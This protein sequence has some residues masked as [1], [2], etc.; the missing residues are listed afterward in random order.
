MNFN[1]KK[2]YNDL[3][4]LP[5]K[6]DLETKEILKKVVLAREALAKLDAS[7]KRLPNQYILVN[8]VVLQEAR[9]S[10]EIE[11]IV[12][13]NDELYQAM[14]TEQ[15]NIN[16]GT[17]EV[18]H[19]PRALWEGFEFVKK[20][21]FMNT[22][23]FIRTVNIIKENQSGIRQMLGTVIANPRTEE[24]F[25]TPPE[26]ENVIREKLKNLEDY[27]NNNSDGI[28]PLVKM[29]AVHYQFEAIHPFYDGNGRTGRIINILF[30]T[31]RGLLERPVL[32]LSKYIIENKGEYYKSIRE[33]TEEGKW[34]KWTMY[35]LNAVESTAKYTENKINDI[36]LL[37][38]KTGEMM[39]AKN[40]NI[41]SRELVDVLFRLPYCKRKF[42]T[43]AGIAKEKTAG[44]YLL[45]LERAGLLKAEK[46]GREKLY[47]NKP[48]FDL[49]KK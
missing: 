24:I 40:S 5:P 11:N 28:D 22:N 18:L 12:T 4:L 49:L 26:G 20:N 15:K 33:V 25:Y 41:Y 34:E 2:P 39:K 8:S 7:N 44:K 19:Y 9:L 23:F 31:M 21:G 38:D 42:L 1:K 6:V 29:A 14:A 46:V 27:L 47:I 35:M 43:D 10:S 32:Y 30:L 37:M 45:E 3:P 17:K 36:C 13:T 16:P 48:F